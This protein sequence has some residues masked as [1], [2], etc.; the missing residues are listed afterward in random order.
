MLRGISQYI[1]AQ[2]VPGL[3]KG[4]HRYASLSADIHGNT[5]VRDHPHSELSIFTSGT[6]KSSNHIIDRITTQ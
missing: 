3:E 4:S 2:W 1:A 6:Y 5:P